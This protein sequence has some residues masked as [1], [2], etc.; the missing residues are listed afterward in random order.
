MGSV[1]QGLTAESGGQYW[2]LASTLDK[3]LLIVEA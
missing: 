3:S 2:G 1:P